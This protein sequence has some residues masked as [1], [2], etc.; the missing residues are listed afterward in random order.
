MRIQELT[1]EQLEDMEAELIQREEQRDGYYS[2][3]INIYKEMHRKLILLAKKDSE[4]YNHYLKYIIKRLIALYIKYGTYLKMTHV[5]D[6]ASAISSLKKAISLDGHNPIAHYRLGFLSYKK[7]DFVLALHYFQ[8]AID[9]QA[10]YQNRE[11]L[12]N[13]Q[14]L[15]HAHMYLTNS[16]LY[17]ANQ[18]YKEMEKLDCE[19]S[20]R[21]PDYEISPI[22]AIL[23]Q[24]ENYL[25]THAFYQ[26]TKNQISQC[27]LDACNEIVENPPKNTMVL[28]FGD[29]ETLCIFNEKEVVLSV[30]LGD[31][32]RH[33]LLMCSEERPG[34]RITL[35]H[36]FDRLGKD[37]EVASA[38]FRQRISRLR[39]KLDQIGLKDSIFQTRHIDETAYYFNEKIS[40][41]V[42]YRIDDI[43]AN[44]YIDLHSKPLV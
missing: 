30:D 21:L 13:Q 6:D 35:R 31:I 3:L 39:S 37:G 1:L 22:Y 23:S 44:E 43:V 28:Y 26:V 2:Q 40:Y 34:T 42:L 36:Y 24:N 14:Q 4:Q 20:D 29:R 16:A 27:S 41:I 38:T 7:H 17:V 8:S 19:D 11:Y 25:R 32:F 18:S 12:L 33:M 5:K 15:F 10:Y 9:Y